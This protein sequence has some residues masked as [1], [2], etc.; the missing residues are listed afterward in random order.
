[1]YGIKIFCVF[2]AFR[3]IFCWYRTRAAPWLDLICMSFHLFHESNLVLRHRRRKGE[4]LVKDYK[5]WIFSKEANSWVP[6]SLRKR[7]SQAPAIEW[8]QNFSLRV[9]Y[10]VNVRCF[11]H[12]P[13]A[14]DQLM[15]IW[16]RMHH[17][18]WVT[19]PL[20]WKTWN[21]G[22]SGWLANHG[23]QPGIQYRSVSPAVGQ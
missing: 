9:V 12:R 4:L 15:I 23:F 10:E 5:P 13:L 8:K 7:F 17:A 1:M 6:N 19:I 11:E 16:R 21:R 22:T 2:F 18:C 3:G 20:N 14:P